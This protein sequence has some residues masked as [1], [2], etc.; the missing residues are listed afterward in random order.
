MNNNDNY[1]GARFYK[2]DLQCQTPEYGGAW[3]PNDLIRIPSPRTQADL[4]EKARTYLRRCHQVGLEVIGITDHN[5]SNERQQQDWFI[6]H[7]IWQNASVAAEV[8]RSPL[9]IFP[10][11]E[12]DIDYHLLCL[13]DPDTPLNE[14]SDCLA[15]LG[16]PLGER[17]KSGQ[18]VPCRFEGR[19]VPLATVLKVVQ[20]ERGGMVIAA[21]AFSNR[22]I[23][24]KGRHPDDYVNEQLM[25]VEVNAAPL[26]GRAKEIIDGNDPTW[27]RRR[28]IAYVMSSDCKKLRPDK[29]E[30]VNFIGYRHTWIKMS[31]PS[32][33]AL[34]QAFLDQE[35]RIRF[36]LAAPEDAYHYPKIRQIS[37]SG[38]SFLADL[39]IAFSPNLTTLIGGRGTGK[40][41]LVEYVRMALGQDS[42]IQGRESKD[43]FEGLRRTLRS[44]SVI[45]VEIE[46]E[47]Q[48]WSISYSGADKTPK[49]VSGA[50]VP[51]ISRFFNVRVLSQREIYS[52]SQD[53][54]A[55]S[56]LIDNLI[57]PALDELARQTQ[58]LATAI[59]ALNARIVAQQEL[60]TRQM[61][62]E[63]DRLD[64]STKLER[65]K[66]LQEPL[67]KWRRLLAEKQFFGGLENEK[68][69]LAR[70]SLE[71]IDSIKFS[72][73]PLS[74][75]LSAGPN[76]KLLQDVANQADQ[77]VNNLRQSISNAVQSFQHEMD[78][79]LQGSAVAGWRS[80]FEKEEAEYLRLRDELTSK[81]TDPESYLR[82]EQEIRSIDIQLATVKKNLD[83]IAEARSSRT[84]K[85][86]GL[87]Q[88]WSRETQARR[89]KCQELMN[90][91]PR[92]FAGEPFVKVSVE[93]F[94][95]DQAFA[96]E[97]QKV[98]QDKRRISDD[99]W[100]TF[101]QGS[102][103]ITPD[104]SF[105]A[106]IVASRNSDQSPVEVLLSWIA[107]LRGGERPAAC[108]W[109]PSERRTKALLE[110]CTE[111][112][113][114]ELPL[115]RPPD[116]LRIELYRQDGS[117][118]G[119]LEEGLSVGQRCT[120]VLA[121]LLAQDDVPAIID[122]PEEDLDNEF[123]YRELVP[124][125]RRAKERRQLIIATH[126]AN[127][128]VNGDA[129][130]IVALEVRS[131]RGEIKQIDSK[132]SIGALDRIPV[133]LAVEEI[134][135]GSEEAFRQRFEKYGF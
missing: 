23:A 76:S 26:T 60:E 82:Y 79:L 49:V 69:S 1:A 61:Q 62:L 92:T 67:S 102:R 63:T 135:E 51:D 96:V 15:T 55:R 128:P 44:A 64:L 87:A 41:T 97:M 115:W 127:I 32:I 47:G 133:R 113:V 104:N 120:A 13:F 10:G 27:K 101:D 103:M 3:A 85:A 70:E 5:F 4:Q 84:T 71:R 93:A 30:D 91:V 7:L 108:P 58:D 132:K 130:L 16:L 81:G 37:V 65:L 105:L 43:N 35:S 78:N 9:I 39:K 17:F 100:G 29:D 94:G 111:T 40:S 124:L 125:L 66:A 123:V 118:V 107:Q 21:H 116:R 126:N 121:L 112:K 117:R 86:T 68:D 46:K 129:E 90:E 134:M 88:L 59:R 89:T 11:F 122:Q 106:C 24:E 98:V 75:E 45:D 50:P 72:A 31:S 18:P 57:R 114:N 25:A 14:V 28:R 80:S 110:W 99:D 2:C 119:E 54:D 6:S 19:P 33:E 48:I 38:V 56:R 12:L 22:G 20:S 53:R 109:D 52:I 8:E 73:I 131:Q 77:L 74:G 42:T 34:R 36:G 83:E 95:D